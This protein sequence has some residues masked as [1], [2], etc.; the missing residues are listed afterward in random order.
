MKK[1]KDLKKAQ[2][3]AELDQRINELVGESK[4]DIFGKII[5][6]NQENKSDGWEDNVWDDQIN[7]VMGSV[8]PKNKLID[9]PDFIIGELLKP[10]PR[11]NQERIYVQRDKITLEKMLEVYKKYN[12]NTDIVFHVSGKEINDVLKSGKGEDAIYFSTDIKR[13][14]NLKSAKYIYAFRLNK[15][16]VALAKYCAVDCFGK[17]KTQDID[18]V[19]ID[20]Y[21]KIFDENNPEYR[22]NIMKKL[23][24]DFEADYVPATD[25][26][27]EF[28]ASR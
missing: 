11:E 27:A 16:N 28:M 25:Q 23:G 19:Q 15:K 4:L 26:A 10:L 9:V 20:D 6:A 2:F 8:D 12:E 21:I 22:K 17:L 24:A 1:N 14:F 7:E 5:E 18:N 3:F 13:L